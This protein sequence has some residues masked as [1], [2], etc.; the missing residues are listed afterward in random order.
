MSKLFLF[1]LIAAGALTFSGC[2]S[3]NKSSAHI[4]EGDAPTIRYAP[5]EAGGALDTY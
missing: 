1:L 5:S 2:A 4:Y 3:R